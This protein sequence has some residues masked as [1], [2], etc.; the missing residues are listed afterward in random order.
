SLDAG[1]TRV[2]AAIAHDEGLHYATGVAH[3]DASRLTGAE[4]AFIRTALA[5]LC[6]LLACGPLAV[7]HEVERS[8]GG[9][10]PVERVQAFA[11][12][13]DRCALHE[14]LEHL[15]RFVAHRGMEADAAW[16]RE[17]GLLAPLPTAASLQLYAPP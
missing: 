16:L 5:E 17:Q 14:R 3:F 2:F 12:L 15:A 9:F 10:S 13:S 4:R 6:T 7:L 8:A 11:D 1:A